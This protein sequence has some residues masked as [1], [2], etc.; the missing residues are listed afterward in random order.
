M[1]SFK[2]ILRLALQLFAMEFR[3]NAKLR[4][5]VNGVSPSLVNSQLIGKIYDRPVLVLADLTDC[6]PSCNK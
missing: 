3:T 1:P 2:I 6:Y 5:T 4:Y